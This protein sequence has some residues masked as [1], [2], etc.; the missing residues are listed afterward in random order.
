M[1]SLSFDWYRIDFESAVQVGVYAMS[2]V[3]RR[4]GPVGAPFADTGMSESFPSYTTAIF[5]PS[6]E[7]AG[8]LPTRESID[9]CAIG[10]YHV[11]SPPVEEIASSWFVPSRK[12]PEYGVSA[13]MSTREPSFDQDGLPGPKSGA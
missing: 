13:A 2:L 12:R 3:R 11:E 9:W 6:G 10:V 1:R 7:I 4:G 5:A 8:P